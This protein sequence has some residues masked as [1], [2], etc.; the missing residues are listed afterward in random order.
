MDKIREREYESFVVPELTDIRSK[1]EAV[2]SKETRGGWPQTLVEIYRNNPD[3]S[4][5][6]VYEYSRNY[7]FMNTFEPFRHLANGRWGEY[8]LISSNYVRFEVVDLVKGEVVAVEPYPTVTEETHERWR[9]NG[10]EDWCEK[11]PV[12]TEKPGWGFCPTD[13]FVPN[14]Y[15]ELIT[16]LDED[17]ELSEQSIGK[18]L[19]KGFERLGSKEWHYYL[20]EE[21]LQL[22]TGQYAFYSGCVWGDDSSMKLNWIDLS[23]L[24]EGIVTSDQ[25]RYG[26][27]PLFFRKNE[28]LKDAIRLHDGGM[29]EVPMMLTGSV[30]GPGFWP[31]NVAWKDEEF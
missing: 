9:K 19:L 23:R 14:L 17:E 4:K 2:P 6:K 22:L 28:R 3:G 15:D 8:A 12:G 10:H 16:W 29:L 27:V 25:S 1:Y 11:D 21:N 26:Y 18:V 20:P 5:D 24:T 13:F 30:R 7:S 31:E